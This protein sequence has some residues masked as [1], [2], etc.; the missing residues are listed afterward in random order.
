MIPCYSS[1]AKG[2]DDTYSSAAKGSDDTYSS[3]AKGSMTFFSASCLPWIERITNQQL[4]T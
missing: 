3:A 2:S 4:P 1:A